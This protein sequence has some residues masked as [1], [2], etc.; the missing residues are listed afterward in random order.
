MVISG[1]QSISF[2]PS[3]TYYA[4]ASLIG[5]TEIS[6]VTPEITSASYLLSISGS[7][8]D[9]TGRLKDATFDST[10]DVLYIGRDSVSINKSWIP[11]TTTFGVT[12]GIHLISATLKVSSYD[13]QTK[14]DGAPCKIKIACDSKANSASPISWAT[15]NSKTITTNFYSDV[16]VATWNQGTIY[17]I[18]LTSS[19]LN[20]F[21][22][23]AITWTDGSRVAVLLQDYGSSIGSYRSIVSSEGAEDTGYQS[24]TLELVYA[25]NYYVD[26]VLDT[27]ICQNK[28]TINYSN[29]TQ[30]TF[31]TYKGVTYEGLIKVN[32]ASIPA[33]ATITSASLCLYHEARAASITDTL[34]IRRMLVPWDLYSATFN[35]K[36]GTGDWSIPGL[37]CGVDMECTANIGLLALSATEANGWKNIPLDIALVEEWINGTFDNNGM[38]FNLQDYTNTRHTFT[39]SRGTIKANHPKMIVNYTVGGTPYTQTFQTS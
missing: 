23:S 8:Q 30:F 3:F 25:D 16:D 31:G 18:D 7:Y 19:A 12:N 26:D 29:N 11:F 10:G 36:Y 33:T 39:S 34:N 17:E 13:T 4:S 35:K 1:C 2:I 32:L 22:G 21:G 15:L 28:P 5:S 37:Y 27:F 20:L 24:P 6:F 9:C 38:Y 14:I